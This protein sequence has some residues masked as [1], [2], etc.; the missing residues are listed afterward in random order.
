MCNVDVASLFLLPAFILIFYFV[1]RNHQQQQQPQPATRHRQSTQS[2]IEKKS[3]TKRR[4]REPCALS[5]SFVPHCLGLRRRRLRR[6]HLHHSIVSILTTPRSLI[7]NVL[8]FVGRFSIFMAFAFVY[9]LDAF[10]RALV[11]TKELMKIINGLIQDKNDCLLK[12]KK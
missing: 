9:T 8:I 4:H 3:R 10:A 5:V 1:S 11:L 2:R 6:L 7:N 12:I